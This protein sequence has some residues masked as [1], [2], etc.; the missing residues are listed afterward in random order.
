MSRYSIVFS[1]KYEK[2]LDKL[3]GSNEISKANAIRNAVAV[4]NLL[5]EET[6]KANRHVAIVDDEGKINKIIVLPQ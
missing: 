6:K 5:N 3:A 1:G 2:I 4:L